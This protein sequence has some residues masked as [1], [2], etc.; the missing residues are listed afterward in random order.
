MLTTSHIESVQE[1]AES[2]FKLMRA[3]GFAP[4]PKCYALW[5]AYFS[6]ADPE[7][8]RILERV[9]SGADD[10]DERRIHELYSQFFEVDMETETIRQT[11]AL[12]EASVAKVIERLNDVRDNAA[13]YGERLDNFTGQL[14]N[15]ISLNLL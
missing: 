12:I 8:E 3:R 10:L 4:T 13:N 9:V 5:Y 6:K 11:G 1:T 15:R 14:S 2:A 7:L